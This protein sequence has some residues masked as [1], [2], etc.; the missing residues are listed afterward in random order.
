MLI[1]VKEYKRINPSK[2]AVAIRI[3]NRL[4]ILIDTTTG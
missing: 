4:V 1:F 2:N 3:D